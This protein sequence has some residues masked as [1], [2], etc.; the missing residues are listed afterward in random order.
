MD[1]LSSSCRQHALF[2]KHPTQ[3]DRSPRG[4]LDPCARAAQ[5]QAEVKHNL[6]GQADRL[7]RGVLQDHMGTDCKQGAFNAVRMVETQV[8]QM[9][10]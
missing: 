5:H 10:D 6:A 4:L 3:Q 2:L 8:R 7:S 1:G 9:E